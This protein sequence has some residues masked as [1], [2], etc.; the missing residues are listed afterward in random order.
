MRIA[1]LGTSAN[2]LHSAHVLI[3]K[4]ILKLNLAD[5]V[6]IIPCRKHAFDKELL[7]WKYRWKMV[8]MLE[9]KGIKAC[10]IEA[11]QKGKNYTINTVRSLKEKYPQHKFYWIIGSD[12][13]ANEGYKK[14][15]NW[16]QL[17]DEIQFLIVERP[18]YKDVKITEKYFIKTG[19]RGYNI[20]STLIRKR[21]KKS[22]SIDSLVPKKIAQYLI[23]L[24][25]NNLINLK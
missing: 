8:K 16:S 9:K 18:G 7:D 1:C 23:H 13:I 25:N 17:K 5:E 3:I 21:L 2:P 22:L 11:K 20:S 4:Q 12:L 24:K 19:I 15:K 14:W 10:D 6:W